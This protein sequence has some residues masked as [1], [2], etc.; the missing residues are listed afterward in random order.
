M[1]E[2]P[3]GGQSRSV[4]ELNIGQVKGKLLSEFL[5]KLTAE[6]VHSLGLVK[7]DGRRL[8]EE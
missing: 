5:S 1:G 8:I 3:F 6:P 7:R 4:Q 2:L